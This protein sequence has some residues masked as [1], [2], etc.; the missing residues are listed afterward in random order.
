MYFDVT[1]DLLYVFLQPYL[2]LP[3]SQDFL[4]LPELLC[5]HSPHSFNF[6]FKVFILSF[7]VTLSEVSEVF[8]SVGMDIS[9]SRQLFSC[10]FLITMSG[11]LVFISRSVRYW[12]IPEDCDVVFLCYYLGLMLARTISRLCLCSSLCRCSRVGMSAGFVLSVKIFSFGQLR[13]PFHNM[14][15]SFLKLTTNPAHWVCTIL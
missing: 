12:H 3:Q 2:Y 7:S 8:F 6:D 1:W 11:L 10:L 5:S 9:I 14:V 4:S 13:A 15:N